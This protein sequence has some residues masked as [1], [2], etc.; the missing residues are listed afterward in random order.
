MVGASLEMTQKKNFGWVASID[1]P[2]VSRDPVGE[3]SKLIS[4]LTLD[5][6]GAARAS[7]VSSH[8]LR[9]T[10]KP[11][12]PAINASHPCSAM[13]ERLARKEFVMYKVPAS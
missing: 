3:S 10:L 2:N 4:M 12:A 9:V 8:H 5:T 13:R 6:S 11:A 1:L 7:S